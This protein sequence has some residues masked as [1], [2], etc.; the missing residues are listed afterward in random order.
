MLLVDDIQCVDRETQYFMLRAKDEGI[1]IIF[2]FNTDKAQLGLPTTEHNERKTASTASD[3]GLQPF[4]V[5]MSASHTQEMT[6]L[7][8]SE[9]VIHLNLFTEQQHYILLTSLFNS[10][11]DLKLREA[12]FEKTCGVPG[13]A[14]QISNHLME[15]AN[16]QV[17]Y[18]QTM[19]DDKYD[20]DEN[21]VRCIIGYQGKVM[22]AID[23]LPQD[24]KDCLYLCS[25]LGCT[26]EKD[27]IFKATGDSDT[28]SMLECLEAAGILLVDGEFVRFR[29]QL[30]K[31]A[32]YASMVKDD[33]QKAHRAIASVVSHIPSYPSRAV[34]RHLRITESPVPFDLCRKAVLEALD[35][36]ELEGCITYL[37]HMRTCGSLSP[38]NNVFRL[39]NLAALHSEMGEFQQAQSA[40]DELTG[41]LNINPKPQKKKFLFCCGGEE[42]VPV[43]EDK[44]VA[45]VLWMGVEV[46]F[47]IGKKEQLTKAWRQ[48]A[49]CVP[50]SPEVASRDVVV[51]LHTNEAHVI[52]RTNVNK[53]CPVAASLVFGLKSVMQHSK[54][55]LASQSSSLVHDLPFE[56]TTIRAV[57]GGGRPSVVGVNKAMQTIALIFKGEH[58]QA[59]EV[60][61]SIRK[62]PS[63]RWSIIGLL[64]K[65]ILARYYQLDSPLLDRKNE[66]ASAWASE[67]EI[68]SPKAVSRDVFLS[69]LI[70]CTQYRFSEDSSALSELKG[71]D[72][73]TPM[74]ALACTVLLDQHVG[75]KDTS[76]E[77]KELWKI[78]KLAITKYP[79]FEVAAKFFEGVT[80][81]HEKRNEE[82]DEL[83]RATG[84]LCLTKGVP[85]C[86]IAWRA[87]ARLLSSP[88]RKIE[89]RFS[90]VDIQSMKEHIALAS[91]RK[92]VA[93]EISSLQFIIDNAKDK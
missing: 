49:A 3:D 74:H 23:T 54:Y 52:S 86:F 20:F 43:E 50:P 65:N 71:T 24:V 63:P 12:I 41:T 5:E 11:V 75:V 16:V 19:L 87:K 9:N 88:A 6:R 22:E 28:A 27:L 26:F 83:F 90:L 58:T 42:T 36:F 21:A 18:G 92:L 67:S 35:A 56:D 72:F 37:N 70:A 57:G 15:S 89:A 13:Y 64:L 79:L 25:T 51:K 47:M 10:D 80:L 44:L 4:E 60:I 14:V 32:I 91:T 7:M 33:R 40:L 78:F 84:E 61:E 62:L 31:D 82:A 85:D 69:P 2:T 73:I 8:K 55:D 30:T 68:L 1:H 38:K 46:A 59:D 93:P 45:T 39:F 48:Y 17:L 81:A 66:V 53:T 34:F 77:V 29:A 76:P